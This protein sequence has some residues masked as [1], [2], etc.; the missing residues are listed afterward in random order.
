MCVLAIGTVLLS[1]SDFIMWVCSESSLALL[2][3]IYFT[4]LY[5]GSSS[6]GSG[7]GS[8]N[9]IINCKDKAAVFAFSPLQC[10]HMF[11]NSAYPI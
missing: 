11:N 7:S 8:G 9:F 6:S 2:L 1:G 3:V 5:G 4:L 10:K